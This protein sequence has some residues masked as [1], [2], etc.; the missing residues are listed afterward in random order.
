[1]SVIFPNTVDKI[2]DACNNEGP[3]IT[4]TMTRKKL[5][6][7]QDAYDVLIRIKY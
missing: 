1:M 3:V 7:I 5:S 4:T 2:R 6:Y